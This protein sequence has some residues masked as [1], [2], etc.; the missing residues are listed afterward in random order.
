MNLKGGRPEK[1]GTIAAFFYRLWA[2]PALSALHARIAAEVPVDEGRLLDVGCGPGRLARLVAMSRPGLFVVGLDAS[3]D[4]IGQARRLPNPGNLEFREGAV[5]SA[6][7]EAG[8][9]HAVT[10][11][12]FHHW[13]EPA[14]GLDAIHRALVPGGEL[15]IYEPDSEASNAE[16]RRDHE[17]LWGWLRMPGGIHRRMSR[18]HGFSLREIDEV[19]RPVVARTAFGECSV[20]RR[21]S[22]LRIRMTRR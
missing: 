10:L 8:F 14:A 5:E 12:S 1:F 15:W 3:P 11:L 4:M 20:E 17:P 6:A 13:E 7:F 9:D 16:I 22:T 19:V 21:G 18:T 2:E